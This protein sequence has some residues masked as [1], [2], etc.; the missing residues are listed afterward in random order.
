MSRR[1][2]S[3][4][5]AEPTHD[6]AT[7][8]PC[9]QSSTTSIVIFG[10]GEEMDME[11]DATARRR[12]ARGLGA[13]LLLLRQ[14]LRQGHGLLRSLPFTVGAMPFHGMSRLSVSGSEHYPDD[15]KH[16]AYQLDWNDRFESGDRSQHYQFNYVP[17]TSAPDANRPTP[18]NSLLLSTAVEQLALL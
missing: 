10:T 18:M 1:G 17:A 7:S 5:S 8:L 2:R 13:R 16:T 4:R 3:S 6:T 14:R 15:R 11:F 9:S 12:I